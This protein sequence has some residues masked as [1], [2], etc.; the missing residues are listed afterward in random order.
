MEGEDKT[1]CDDWEVCANPRAARSK[2]VENGTILNVE[3]EG[4]FKLSKQPEKGWERRG[5]RE[6]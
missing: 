6:T 2:G 5:G 1:T 4:S 3:Q